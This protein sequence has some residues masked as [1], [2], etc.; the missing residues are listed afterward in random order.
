MLQGKESARAQTCLRSVCRWQYTCD[1]SLQL[2]LLLPFLLRSLA[3]DAAGPVSNPW[4]LLQRTPATTQPI[5]ALISSPRTPGDA[6]RQWR[7]QG[8]FSQTPITLNPLCQCPGQSSQCLSTHGMEGMLCKPVPS[9]SHTD[10]QLPLAPA[11]GAAGFVVASH[12]V[13]F[14]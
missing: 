2:L 12:C 14:E 11:V 3:T 7:G 1:L 5:S 6:T 13:C 10:S 4:L 8:L 9:Q